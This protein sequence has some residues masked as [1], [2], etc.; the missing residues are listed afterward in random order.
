M[1]LEI[2]P[3]TCI[4]RWFHHGMNSIEGTYRNPD[5]EGQYSRWLMDAIK[6]QLQLL[7]EVYEDTR[8]TWHTAL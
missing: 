3:E 8:V 1:P 6:R 2:C 4:V 5:G 7:T